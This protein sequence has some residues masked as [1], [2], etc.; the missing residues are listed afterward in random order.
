[1]VQAEA[2]FA[3]LA[4]GDKGWCKASLDGL[5]ASAAP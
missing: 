4:D 3:G 2:A 1:V 5:K